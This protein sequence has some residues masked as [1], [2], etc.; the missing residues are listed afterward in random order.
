MH[1]IPIEEGIRPMINRFIAEHWFSTLM[2]V[3]GTA[4]DMT[5]LDGF[6]V[7]EDGQVTG[8]VTYKTEDGECEIMSLDSLKENRGIGTGLVNEVVAAARKAGCRK[9]KL[10]TTND[11]LRA[12]SFYQKRGFDMAALYRNALDAAR[13]IKPEIPLMGENNI[14]LRH[15]IEFELSL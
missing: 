1:I 5:E 9:V 8:L 11:N 14:P 13:A 3:R 12:F 4:V 15:E 10:V 7:L 6:A 2:V